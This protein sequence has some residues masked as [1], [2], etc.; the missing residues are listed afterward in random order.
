MKNYFE[1]RLSELLIPTG[2]AAIRGRALLLHNDKHFV[3]MAE[4]MGLSQEKPLPLLWQG[5]MDT[6]PSPDGVRGL[7]AD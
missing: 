4:G 1:N 7:S 3:A 5:Q 6:Y 2:I